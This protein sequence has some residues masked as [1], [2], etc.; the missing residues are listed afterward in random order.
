MFLAVQTDASGRVIKYQRFSVEADANAHAVKF[1][2]VVI[3]DD[4]TDPVDVVVTNGVPEVVPFEPNA[5]ILNRIKALEM[6]VT[7]RRLREAA[8]GT[9]GGWLA[10]QDALMAIE[11]GK[12]V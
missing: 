9:D 3:P 4:G 11:R 7:Q 6:K 1:S 12:L 10:N 8:L 5:P 2:G